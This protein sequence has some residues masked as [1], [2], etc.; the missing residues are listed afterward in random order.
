MVFTILSIISPDDAYLS[1]NNTATTEIYTCLH[2]LSL[3]D[4]LPICLSKHEPGGSGGTAI[5][6]YR[7]AFLP[8]RDAASAASSEDHTSELQSLMRISYAVFSLKNKHNHAHIL[9]ARCD[10]I[11]SLSTLVRQS[12]STR[13]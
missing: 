9:L 11:I 1:F 4:A 5:P 8:F 6:G 10:V 12:H 13:T 7:P 2:T 3:H